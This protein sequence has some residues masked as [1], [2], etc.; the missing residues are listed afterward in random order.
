MDSVSVPLFDLDAGPVTVTLRLTPT[1]H[2]GESFLRRFAS[3]A[4]C[5]RHITARSRSS[6]T[7]P[8][9]WTATLGQ[10][11]QSHMYS[12]MVSSR[13]STTILSVT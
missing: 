3:C 2:R 9:T 4:A 6:A 12:V 1:R 8:T 10:S 13:P 5:S 11:G 7:T